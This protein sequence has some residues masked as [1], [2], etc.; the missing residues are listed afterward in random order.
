MFSWTTPQKE[1]VGLDIGTSSV[2]IVQLQRSRNSYRL[3]KLAIAP[4]HPE[5]IVDGTIMDA[6]AISDTIQQLFTEHSIAV[7]DVAFSVS[8]HSVIVKKIKVPQMKKAELRE[9][10]AWEAEQH[11]PY[12]MEDVNLD[13]Q[14]LREA[15]PGEQEMDV[16][17]VAVKKET[18]ND[19]LAMI[20]AAGLSAAVVDVDAFAIEN[21]F[22]ISAQL[23][24]DEVVALVNIGAAVT[25]INI[26]RGGISD[27]TRD[28]SVGGNRH[29]ESLQQSLGVSVEE[30]E[31]IKRG[32]PVHGHNFADARPVIEQV[33]S[34]LA[35]EIRRSFDFYH[36]TS[37]SETIHRMVLSGGCALLPDLASY[38]SSALALPVEIADPF[39]HV[40]AD[41]KE[42]DAEYL[43]AI[44]PQMTVAVGLALRE[45]GD[46]AE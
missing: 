43:A 18:L 30:A 34:E 11:I 3:A 2:K 19:Y 36:S 32:E 42:F 8:G 31:A 44:A 10:I 40:V 5:T 35:G 4:I 9:G 7:K 6:V 33:N 15:G 26:L 27:F 46:D 16:L 29:T 17:L 45:P 14:I 39:H 38:L 23:Q 20:A 12:S 22:T 1:L 41:P 28:S 21:A 25:T 13:F 24:P 37:Q